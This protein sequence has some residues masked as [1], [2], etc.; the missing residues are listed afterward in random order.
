MQEA[1][2]LTR[3]LGSGEDFP[4]DLADAFDAACNG[5]ENP[6]ALARME[7]LTGKELQSWKHL[8][9][10]IRAMYR[11]DEES[12]RAA[13]SSI[14]DASPPSSLKGLFSAWVSGVKNAGQANIAAGGVFAAPVRE[15]YRKLLVRPHPLRIIA[16]QADEALRQGMTGH[17]E[18]LSQSVFRGLREERRC[19]SALL[20]LRYARYCLSL[21][22][23]GGY[24]PTDFFSL[25]VKVLG[26]ADGF[27]VIGMSLLDDDEEA[28]LEA[29]EAA[30]E[31]ARDQIQETAE[32]PAPDRSVFLD[33]EM[34]LALRAL[35]GLIPDVPGM[36]A[37]SG[38]R[39]KNSR[40]PRESPGQLE[41]F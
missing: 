4:W 38:R 27:L 23:E 41:L 29:L 40:G 34:A 12:C 3:F 1:S 37:G 26:R 30:L 2:C 39:P 11:G 16:E 22:N 10:A 17:F 9:H 6:E 20:A 8:V 5:L 31:A 28:A 19:D 14:D 13:S 24:T 33:A 7:K 32:G 25:I 18:R 15:L 36:A 21:L 35:T